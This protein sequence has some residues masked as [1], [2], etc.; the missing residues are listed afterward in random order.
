MSNPAFG[1]TLI[2]IAGSYWSSSVIRKSERIGE[3]GLPRPAGF[4]DR[5]RYICRE[6]SIRDLLAGNDD[7]A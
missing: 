1:E 4:Y 7:R 3:A 6:I 5:K 2:S